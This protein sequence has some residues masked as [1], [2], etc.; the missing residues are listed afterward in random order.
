[1]KYL[2]KWEILKS[3]LENWKIVEGVVG[4]DI[5]LEGEKI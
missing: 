1:M 5:G 4:C 2:F 3:F